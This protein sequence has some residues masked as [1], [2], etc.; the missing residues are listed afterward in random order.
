[1]GKV[2]LKEFMNHS[3]RVSIIGLGA[4]GMSISQ[5][6]I[7]SGWLVFG[8]DVCPETIKE[9]K[10]NGGLPLGTPSEAA[11]NCELMLLMVV[12]EKQCEEVLFGEKGG[13]NN[14]HK[15]SVVINCST[16]SSEFAKNTAK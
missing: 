3:K 8:V 13:C 12:N 2:E 4:M 9:F 16:V 1:V 15:G 11:K 14:F 5:V 10:K 6:L 7:K